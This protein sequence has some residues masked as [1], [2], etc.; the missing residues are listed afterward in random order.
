M[1]VLD[2]ISFCFEP[3]FAP[4]HPKAP[5]AN[6]RTSEQNR[7]AAFGF[8]RVPVLCRAKLQRP[9]WHLL[10]AFRGDIGVAA[11]DDKAPERPRVVM[12][13]TGVIPVE[14]VV[15]PDGEELEVKHPPLRVGTLGFAKLLVGDH[16]K[17]SVLMQG[18]VSFQPSKSAFAG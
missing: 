5:V 17:I 11:L 7:P 14:P 9:A 12:V 13:S 4:V 16:L 6:N 1:P 8:N 2:E 15:Q 10:P 3:R 18:E